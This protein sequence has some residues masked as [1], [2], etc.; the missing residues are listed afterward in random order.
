MSDVLNC[1]NYMHKIT[2]RQE[3]L[4]IILQ[5]RLLGKVDIFMSINVH[6]R[7]DPC[8]LE[9]RRARKELPG[10]YFPYTK[11]V[12]SGVSIDRGYVVRRYWKSP[13]G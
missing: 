8:Y 4:L 1:P 2:M 9:P 11:N 5:H 13:D 10:K 3:Q 6:S 12:V 7:Q